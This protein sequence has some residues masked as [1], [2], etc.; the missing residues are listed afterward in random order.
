[1]TLRPDLYFSIAING[2]CRVIQYQDCSPT[3]HVPVYV[4]G[5]FTSEFVTISHLVVFSVLLLEPVVHVGT[6]FAYTGLD[7]SKPMSNS[8][9]I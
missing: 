8:F 5:F 6:P 3:R 4:V 9:F 2:A 1:M 7:K